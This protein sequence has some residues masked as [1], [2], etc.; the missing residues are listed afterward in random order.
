[1]TP[2]MWFIWLLR[3]DLRDGAPLESSE[4]QRE[5]VVWWLLWG[6]QMYRRDDLGPEVLATVMEPVLVE[7]RP[8]PRLLRRLHRASTDLQKLFDITTASGLAEYLSWYRSSG[9]RELGLAPVEPEAKPRSRQ[10]PKSGREGGPVADGGSMSAADGGLQAR[11]PAGAAALLAPGG[12]VPKSVAPQAPGRTARGSRLG[13]A[14]RFGAN[15]VGFAYGELGLGEDVRMLSAALESAG[16]EHAVIDVPTFAQTRRGDR[17]VAHRVLERPRY[18]VTIFCLSPFDTADFYARGRDDLFGAEYN[19]GYWPWELP[20]MPGLWREAYGLVDEVWAASRYTAGAFQR[21]SP[22]PVH[23]MPPCVDIPEI[24]KVRARAAKLR[25]ARGARFR[26]FY[27]FDRNSFL[28]RKN[29]AAAIAA[30]RRAF[31]TADDGVE[32]LLRVNGERGNDEDV[33]LLRDQARGDERIVLREGT[34]SRTDALALA[35]SADCLVSPHRAEGFGRNIAEALLLEVAV[36]AT[37]FGG[38]VDFL[39]SGEAIGWRPVAVRAGEY[40]HADGQWWAEP[41]AEHLAARMQE[42]REA[43]HHRDR[44]A[45]RQRRDQFRSVYGPVPAGARYA[46][47][48]REIH[49]GLAG[50]ERPRSMREAGASLVQRA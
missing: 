50:A 6:H 7:G 16:I 45:A 41:D 48:L 21:S 18:P 31:P 32:L 19:I 34:L 14:T 10:S 38:C 9:Q 22:V 2:A 3:A 29:P 17:S 37:G 35:A 40:P 46:R 12:R 20:E 5:F 4:A 1:M 24:A 25:E 27:P 42:I 13:G 11:L 36:L 47:R 30:F 28:A 26:F 23:V 8:L 39:H 15:L 43:G 33:A 49:A 44:S